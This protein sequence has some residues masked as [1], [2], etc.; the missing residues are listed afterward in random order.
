MIILRLR[1]MIWIAAAFFLAAISAPGGEFDRIKNKYASAGMI[2]LEI[3]IFIK[4]EVFDDIDTTY[5]SVL[6]ARDGRYLADIGDDIYLFD[7]RCSWEYSSENNQA[8]KRCLKDDE[9][10]EHSFSFLRDL[11]RFYKSFDSTDDSLY[12]MMK[13]KKT[14][15]NLPDTLTVHLNDSGLTSIEYFDLNGDL[16]QVFILG[17]A[18]S[19]TL[20]STRFIFNLPDSAEVISL[21]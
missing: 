8:T 12:R 7:G 15:S 18:F 3:K 2:E 14:E 19:D 9:T 20:D 11:D 5:G 13:V 16:N 4:S 6:I 17:Q 1:L 10:W 21:P